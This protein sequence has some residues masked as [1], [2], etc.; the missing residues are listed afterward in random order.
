MLVLLGQIKVAQNKI[1]DAAQSYKE[2]IARQPNDPLGYRA[3][4]EFYTSQKNWKD[5]ENTLQA[6]L[7]QMPSDMNL[8]LSMQDCRFS[9][10]IRR[11]PLDNMKRS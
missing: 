3:L 2:A 6:I 5:A 9:R 4:T 1:D 8:R 11:L 7:K 10:E